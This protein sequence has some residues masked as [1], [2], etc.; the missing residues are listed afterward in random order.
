MEVCVFALFARRFTLAARTCELAI[1]DGPDTVI[2]VGP[3]Q[4]ASYSSVAHEGKVTCS[5]DRH[6]AHEAFTVHNLNEISLPKGCSAET[7]SHVFT[8]ADS[9]FTR[10]EAQ[11]TIGYSWPVDTHGMLVGM[12]TERFAEMVTHSENAFNLTTQ[13]EFLLDNALRDIQQHKEDLDSEWDK[14]HRSYSPIIWGV[15]VGLILLLAIA[16][17]TLGYFLRKVYSQLPAAL[18]KQLPAL[19]RREPMQVPEAVPLMLMPTTHHPTAPQPTTADFDTVDFK[20]LSAANPRMLRSL[21]AN[22]NF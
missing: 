19:Q 21:E 9:S 13:A 14:I 15:F 20:S 6:R 1:G 18:Q 2:Q 16:V 5:T 22:T 12:N 3:R 11:W 10:D 4:F 17:L 8:S 7:D